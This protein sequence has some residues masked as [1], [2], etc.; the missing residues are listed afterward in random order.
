MVCGNIEAPCSSRIGDDGCVAEMCS[1][2]VR[3]RRPLTPDDFTQDVIKGFFVGKS[4]RYK[5]GEAY[6][7]KYH[8]GREKVSTPITLNPTLD[9]YCIGVETPLTSWEVEE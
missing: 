9:K 6:N 3:G 8:P 1:F 4:K 7:I 5:K 2:L